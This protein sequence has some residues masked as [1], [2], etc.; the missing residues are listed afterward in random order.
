MSFGV[1]TF[2][3]LIGVFL[4]VV[5]FD[6]VRKRKFREELSL[7]WLLVGPLLILSS[8]ADLLIDPIA[9][10]LGIHYPPALIFLIVFFL[11]TLT[12]LYFSIVVSDLK[13]RNKEL[14][15]KIALVEFKISRLKQNMPRG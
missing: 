14:S 13:C 7:I 6:L 11:L 10:R 3:F 8:L 15:Q 12:L 1:R 4:F 9:L 2:I 5:I